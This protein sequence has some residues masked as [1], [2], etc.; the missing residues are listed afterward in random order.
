MRLLGGRRDRKTEVIE[1]TE[2]DF[3]P[4]VRGNEV[5]AVMVYM[6]GCPHCQRMEPV[7]GEL[8]IELSERAFF[9]RLNAPANVNVAVKFSVSGVPT[10]LMFKE[11]ELVIEV[12]GE[13]AKE[14]LR[15]AIERCL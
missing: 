13:M 7:F 11:G 8:Q 14:E 9:A 5:C 15:A 3:E 6:P 12:E 4:T 10:F 2:A 1:L